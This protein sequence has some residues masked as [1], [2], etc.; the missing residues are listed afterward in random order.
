[1]STDAEIMDAWIILWVRVS[2]EQCFA[3]AVSGTSPTREY[4]EKERN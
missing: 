2:A 1:M 3:R 4:G